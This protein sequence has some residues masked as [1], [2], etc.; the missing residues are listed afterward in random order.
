MDLQNVSFT[1]RKSGV[2]SQITENANR[3]TLPLREHSVSVSRPC[4]VVVVVVG[5]AVRH[6]RRQ[7]EH[8]QKQTRKQRATHRQHVQAPLHQI[9]GVA[10]VRGF[11]VDGGAVVHKVRDVGDVDADFEVAVGQAACVQ[12]VVDVFA[13]RGVDGAHV[14]VPQVRAPDGVFGGDFVVGGRQARHDRSRKLPRR[15]VVLQQQNFCLRFFVANDAKGAHVVAK[16][17]P[18]HPK[19]AKTVTQTRQGG[20]SAPR[21][22]PTLRLAATSRWP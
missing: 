19:P 14:Q 6:T 17:K 13:A 21:Q 7:A 2:I 16:R 18:E 8:T 10:P 3:S 5:V 11:A 4:A 15:N 1:A 12:G 22:L 20:Q 9:R